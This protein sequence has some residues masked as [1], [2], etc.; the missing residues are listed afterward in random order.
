ML[1]CKDDWFFSEWS[2]E[3][4]SENFSGKWFLIIAKK[5]Y[6]LGKD[7]KYQINSHIA[8]LFLPTLHRII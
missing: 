3:L 2:G 1:I 4:S 7:V 6:N 5:K 8:S